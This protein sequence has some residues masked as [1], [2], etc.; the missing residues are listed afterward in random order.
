M[1]KKLLQ[2]SAAISLVLISTSTV[3]A[4][5]TPETVVE[6]LKLTGL[7]DAVGDYPKNFK[8]G[9][10]QAFERDQ[11]TSQEIKDALYTATEN[12]IKPS[13]ILLDISKSILGV[14]EESELNEI[15]EWYESDLGKKIAQ[16]EKLA[17]TPEALK[18]I[19][20]DKKALLDQFQRAGFAR[21]IEKLYSKAEV[22][23]LFAIEVAMASRTAAAA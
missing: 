5:A 23:N 1:L 21:N 7:T 18:I 16:E 9:I 20:R 14:M 4:K 10:D 11:Q 8:T 12:T 3:F 2:V 13:V 15:I 17:N 6:V 22:T 19:A